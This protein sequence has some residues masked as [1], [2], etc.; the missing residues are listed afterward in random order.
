[1]TNAKT[2]I[3]FSQM[4]QPLT[5]KNEITAKH[6]QFMKEKAD[7]LLPLIEQAIDILEKR[8]GL[9]DPLPDEPPQE[10][11]EHFSAQD[12]RNLAPVNNSLCY[13]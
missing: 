1:M 8:F 12:A 4:A 10:A 6:N 13:K 2:Q 7:V 9:K 3:F 5:G 11:P